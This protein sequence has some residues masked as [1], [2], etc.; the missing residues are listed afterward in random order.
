MCVVCVSC[1]LCVL[2]K[3]IKEVEEEDAGGP[4]GP[5]FLPS[6][7]F[8]GRKA[9]FEFKTGTKGSGYYRTKANARM[10]G[11]GGGGGADDDDLQAELA[12]F[13]RRGV[14]SPQ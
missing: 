5:D 12:A 1:L 3:A 6:R 9:G 4:D 7:T 14:R 8:A 2:R 11:G 10:G 13:A